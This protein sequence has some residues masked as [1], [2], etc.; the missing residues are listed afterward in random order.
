MGCGP[1]A[2]LWVE[3]VFGDCLYSPR[4]FLGF[5]FGLASICCWL[6]AQMPQL[7]RNYKTQSAEALSPWFLAEWLLGD[8][9]N[10]V[11][12]LLKGDQLPTVTLTAEY[13]ICVDAVM[14]VQYTYLTALQRRRQRMAATARRSRHH[15]HHH[16]HHRRHTTTGGG[17]LQQQCSGG[18][19][20]EARGSLGGGGRAAAAAGAQLSPGVQDGEICA[21][22]SASSTRAPPAAAARDV[23]L[24]PQ[25]ALACLGSL[26]LVA[27]F[28][29]TQPQAAGAEQQEA[30]GRRLLLL[31]SAAVGRGGG[32]AS[33][34]PLWAHTAGT[35]IGYCS[36]LL[37]L[38][39][40]LSQIYKNQRRQSVQGL[41]ISMFLTAV[42]AN[43]FYG[44]SILIR[45]T[46]WA[47]LRSSLPWLIGSL[48]TVALDAV[49]VAQGR[50]YGG[51]GEAH[52]H[53]PSDEDEPLLPAP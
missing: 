37:Y 30:G 9:C 1:G 14:L 31:A 5:S 11:G 18:G 28:Q 33:H 43:S 38:T 35:V 49:I 48:G 47:D 27:G 16:H 42:A 25:R 26:L 34:L 32:M 40:R 3:K 12:A 39:S 19:E 29:H 20:G 22:A 41:A 7:Y 10:L 6:F 46:R 51:G 36:S 13:F 52:K 45:S 17:A 8:T 44:S 15:H 53:H 2:S 21:N 24:R 23:V 50:R 4:D